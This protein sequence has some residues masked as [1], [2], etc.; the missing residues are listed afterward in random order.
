MYFARRCRRLNA[1]RYVRNR[2]LNNFLRRL[3]TSSVHFSS[4]QKAMWLFGDPLGTAPEQKIKSAKPHYCAVFL[5][6]KCFVFFRV[7]DAFLLEKNRSLFSK[8]FLRAVQPAFST[9]SARLHR[10]A[11]SIC[12][13]NGATVYC[14]TKCRFS[15]CCAIICLCVFWHC[16][17]VSA[18][19]KFIHKI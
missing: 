16:A 11:F 2:L 18:H 17:K 8:F 4:P 10:R 12:T 5:L 1:R 6:L 7:Q 13:F 14:E 19:S 9:V 3:L 15:N